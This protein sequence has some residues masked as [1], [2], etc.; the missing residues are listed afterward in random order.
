MI[1][2]NKIIYQIALRTFTPEGTLKAATALLPHV[3]SLNVEIVYLGPVFKE[4]ADEDRITWSPRQIASGTNNAKN[5]YKIIDYFHVDE[6]YGTDEDLKDFIKEAHRLGLLV[7]LDLVYLHCGRNAV[8]LKDHP[9]F[10]EC[11]ENG[12][13][14]IGAEWPFARLNFESRALREYL[15]DHM[16]T[17]VSDFCADGFRCDVG[18]M[19]PLDF[20]Q[21]AISEVRKI[22]PDLIMLDEGGNPEYVRETF[23]MIYDFGWMRRVRKIFAGDLQA[24]ELRNYYDLRLEKFGTRANRRLCSLDNHDEAS[25][26][27]KARNEIVMTTEGVEAALVLSLTFQGIPFIWNGY[28]VC[29]D[30]ENCMFS[31]RFHGRKSAIDWSKGFTVKGSRRLTFLRRLNAFY[32]E[33]R[34]AFAGD[35]LWLDH[36][37]SESVLA[38]L[39]GDGA[40]TVFVSVNCKNKNVCASFEK[41]E[42]SGDIVMSR[43]VKI[44]D[45]KIIFEPYGYI[46]MA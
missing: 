27:G 3:A 23:D 37:A 13:V 10:V 21:D 35:Q 9:D 44:Q 45:E 16:K 46:V 24:C 6:E 26:C 25:D 30:A 15:I 31:N 39:R 36:D 34:A 11:D 29:D 22:N 20:W 41:F 14:K 4:D 42:F 7:F 40:N 38:Y 1:D 19:I 32:Q 8:F 12:E 2:H 18:D 5:P 28:E 33:K 43:G 17:L